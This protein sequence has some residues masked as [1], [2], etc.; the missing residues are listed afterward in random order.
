M[1]GSWPGGADC[2]SGIGQWVVSNCI[3]HHLSFLGFYFSL[4]FVIFLF[5]TII[6]FYFSY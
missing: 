2:C 4:F 6:I 5:I 1:E 3:V